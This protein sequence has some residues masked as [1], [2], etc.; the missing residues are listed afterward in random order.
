MTT[1]YAPGNQAPTAADPRP[2]TPEP[3]P[4]PTDRHT[5]PPPP[6]THIPHRDADEPPEPRPHRS[7][8]AMVVGAAL[9]VLV[10]GFAGGAAGS[11][12]GLGTTMTAGSAAPAVAAAASSSPSVGGTKT[13]QQVSAAL[14]PS[15]V[16]I[17]ATT[18]SGVD[19]GSGVILSAGG[20][21]LTNNHVISGAS[22]LQVQFND[23]S[24]ATA[25]VV[26]A[27][28]TDDLAV[29]QAH[30]A[31]G[32]TPA[33]LGTSTGLQVGQDVVAI[34]SP[35]GLSATVTSGIVSALDRPVVT[36]PDQ[37]STPGRAQTSGQGTV[38]D[39]IQTDAP[40]NPGNSGGPLVD[41]TGKV[42]GIN[43]AIASLST[44]STGQ[45]GSIGV[46]FAIPIDQANR[47]A[48]DIINTGQATHAVLG[49]TVTDATASA[50][51]PLTIGATLGQITP[52]SGAATAGLQSGDVVTQLGD[53]PINSADALVAAVRS[54]TPNST[55]HLTYTRGGATTT[56]TVTLG[57]ATA[58]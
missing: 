35:L 37:S 17:V 45:A 6:S 55:V 18:P 20:L 36:T 50:N 15:V 19:E 51:S 11:A 22:T 41:M 44:A 27:D 34:G 33:P 42:I 53:Q 40:I 30:G 16:S 49:A 47:I 25:T 21:I 32:L 1:S 39:A 7:R 58:G 13:V 14:L 56:V 26:G 38:I 4:P 10:L 9:L 23:N 2:G 52:G 8:T 57:T 48:Q 54:A 24:I 31:S 28:T 46:G 3:T 43:S 29:I 12:L 5:D